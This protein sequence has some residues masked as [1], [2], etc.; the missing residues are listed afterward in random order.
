[1]I[2]LVRNEVMKILLKK[3][4]PLIMILLLIFVG[5][6]SYGQNYAYER[7][8]DQFE[9]ES[10]ETAFDWQGLTTQRLDE[11]EER[12]Q[13]EAIPGEV[14]ASFDREIEQLNYFIENDINPVTPTAAKFN[15]SFAEQGIT[16]FIPLLIAILAAD[17]V[18]SEFSRKTIKI[19]LTRAVPRW[20]VLLS[21]YIALLIMTTL[22]V[23]IIGITTTLVSYLFFQEWGFSEPIVTG[24]T[25]FEGTLNSDSTILIPRY[26]YT[27]LIY[28]LVWFVSII[29]ASITLLISLIV[30]T[31]ASA[32]GILMAA[33]IGGQF[34]QFFLSDW[35]LVKYF[36]V[37]NLD[38]TRYLTGSYQPVE[39]MSLNFSILILSV[40]AIGSIAISFIVFNRRDVLV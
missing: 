32:I 33:L 40:W 36:F 24:F 25:L 5:L 23:F 39:G 17:L 13:N 29:V 19:L 38:L 1:M 27:L 10:G 4:M 3:K 6:L 2:A 22:L 20:K 21:K 11:L 37:T 16:L 7:N 35:E 30:D 28:S 14:R 12:S 31:S 34:L 15:V 26:Q 18:S 9:A 8:I